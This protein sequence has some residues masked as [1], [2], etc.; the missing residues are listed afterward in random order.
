[1]R[2]NL[3]LLLA[4]VFA[5]TAGCRT[6][7]QDKPLATVRIHLEATPSAMDFTVKVPVYR[8]NPLM[9]SVDREPF[10]T[11]ADVASAKVVETNGGFALQIGF[12]HSGTLLFEEYTT[13]NPGRRMAIFSQFGKTKE[14]ARWLGAPTITKRLSNGQLIFTPDA[15]REECERIVMGLNN[16]L[17]TKE[18]EAKW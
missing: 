16:L 3:N 15:T 5:L 12:D 18:K 4:I 10:L 6:S 9:I 8:Q 13:A 7:K 2:F 14:E 1:M 11:E 17:E